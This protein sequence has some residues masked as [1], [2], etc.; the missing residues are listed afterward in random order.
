[1]SSL[2]KK[3]QNIVGFQISNADAWEK[4]RR[5]FSVDKFS[6]DIRASYCVG[7]HKTIS[8]EVLKFL[9]KRFASD[10]EVAEELGMTRSNVGQMRLRESV[11][12]RVLEYCVVNLGFRISKPATVIGGLIEATAWTRRHVFGEECDSM[13]QK[14]YA[15]LMLGKTNEWY[16]AFLLTVCEIDIKE[17]K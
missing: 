16:R 4:L 13:T 8:R 7:M 10:V 5:E 14:K 12:A 9:R 2:E 3:Q 11:P 6:D 15:E 17:K 1:M